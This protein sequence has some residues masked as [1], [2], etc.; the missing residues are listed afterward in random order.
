[1]SNEV[2]FSMYYIFRTWGGIDRIS[3][4]PVI[5]DAVMVVIAMYAM[6]FAHPGRLGI[7]K[8]P[9]PADR[10]VRENAP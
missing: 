7:V 8:E 10:E 1:M 2:A 5:L 3:L 9:E 6:N 4:N